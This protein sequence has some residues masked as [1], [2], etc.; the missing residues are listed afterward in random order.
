MPVEAT[1]CQAHLLH[2]RADAACVPTLLPDRASSHGK[3]LFVVPRFVFHR[4]SHDLRVRSYSNGVKRQKIRLGVW[5]PR[6][7]ISCAELPPKVAMLRWAIASRPSGDC[8]AASR[9]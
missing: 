3:N 8:E 4:V 9:R 6:L 7:R 2:H 1:F 5:M